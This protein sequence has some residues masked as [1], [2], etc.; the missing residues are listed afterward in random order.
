MIEL[1]IQLEPESTVPMYEQ[2][3]M[4]IKEEIIRG[5]LKEGVRL[6]STRKLAE[7]LQISRTTI[8]IAYSQLCSEGYL[9]AKPYRGYF[10]SDVS[11]IWQL[12]DPEPVSESTKRKA[13]SQEARDE[14]EKTNSRIVYDFS[15]FGTDLKSFPMNTW[16]KVSKSVLQDENEELF[17]LGDKKG[18]PQFRQVICDYLHQARGVVCAPEQVIVGAGTDFLLLVLSCV[19]GPDHVIAM[20]NPTYRKAYELLFSVGYRIRVVD[21]DKHGMQVDRLEA[22]GADIAYV[23]PSHQFPLGT[24]MPL[25]RRLELL[26]WASRKDRYLIEDDYD[27]EFR[28]KGK[29][30][31]ALQG[32]DPNGRVI[33]LGTFSRAIAPSIRISYLVL[34]QSLLERY[35]ERAGM[36]NSTVS[37]VDQFIL[38]TF[39][40]QGHFERHLNRVKAIYKKRHDCLLEELRKFSSICRVIGEYAG[41]HL[42][43]SFTNGWTEEKIVALAAKK[44]VRVYGLSGY[45]VQPPYYKSEPRIL[46]GYSG[47]TEEEIRAACV[48]LLDAW[49]VKNG[50][51]EVR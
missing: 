14:V 24:V 23:M 45:Y 7:H 21:M 34:P 30:I 50:E 46:L 42:L 8:D 28:Y 1:T 36:I 27:S 38:T 3:Y 39:I 13:V 49:D 18:E 47:L 15:P 22:S 35:R 16:R 19:L 26:E 25:K 6:P 12:T 32:S 4:Y 41:V 17:R 9:E 5:E 10:V 51:K 11:Q 43:L 31:P 29:P 40:S 33:Y 20:E 48:L 2:I 37:R 44:G